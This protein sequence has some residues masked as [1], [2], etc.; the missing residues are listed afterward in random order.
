MKLSLGFSPCP[1]DT[2]IF[3]AL[4]N[5]KIPSP[6]FEFEIY[7]EDVETLNKWAIAGKLDITKLSYHA[8][9]HCNERYFILN[10]G[11]A[12]GRN[13]GPLV[14]SKHKKLNKEPKDWLV[15]IPGE[16]TTAHF[17]FS[18]F[19]PG[20]TKKK[21]MVFSDIETAV[22]KQDVDAGVI[23]HENRFTFQDKGLHQICDLGYSWEHHSACPIPL[24]G[25]AINRSLPIEVA[26]K[27]NE[28]IKKSI[29]YAYG[30]K[31]E[32]SEYVLNHSQEMSESIIYKH[33]QTYVNNYS[34]DLGIEGQGAI[35]MFFKKASE[36][37]I[38]KPLTYNIFLHK[39]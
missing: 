38:I 13:C 8:Y 37:N 7:M 21:F 33:I 18:M 14:I 22:L 25:I 4:V 3:D 2:F 10:S 31:T 32:N 35:E 1:N 19:Y 24:G 26:T 12:L 9:A 27:I 17:L 23:I 20:V 16:L 39:Y 6:G 28:F 30:H 36:L 11:S 34:L 29:E 5:N 15:A